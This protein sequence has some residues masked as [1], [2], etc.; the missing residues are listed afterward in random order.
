MLEA[1]YVNTKNL[2]EL[3]KAKAMTA[4]DTKEHKG[5]FKAWR[6]PESLPAVPHPAG[7]LLPEFAFVFP[8]VLC[9]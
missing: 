3:Q 2:G 5:E 8:G 9:G 6:Q 4:K 7:S 1:G